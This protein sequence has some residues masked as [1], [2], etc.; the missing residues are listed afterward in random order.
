MSPWQGLDFQVLA[1]LPET[2][3]FKLKFQSKSSI[4]GPRAPG[5]KF[6]ASQSSGPAR[7]PAG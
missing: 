3:D 5:P 1:D 7:Q 6:V 2:I 4:S